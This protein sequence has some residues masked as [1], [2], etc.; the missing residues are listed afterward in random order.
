VSGQFYISVVL[1]LEKEPLVH[2]GLKVVWVSDLAW[3]YWRREKSCPYQDLNHSHAQPIDSQ[4][5][6]CDI[7]AVLV[8][9]LD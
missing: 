3:I 1:P 9:I 5:I 8:S 2:T 6:D 7:L 4:F